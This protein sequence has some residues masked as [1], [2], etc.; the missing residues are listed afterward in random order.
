M[1]SDSMMPGATAFTRTPWVAHS[2]PRLIVRFS[3]PARAAPVCAMPGKPRDTFAVTFTM[4]PARCGISAR[5]A[6]SRVML[7]VPRRL[8]RTTASKPRLEIADA[9]AGN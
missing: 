7:N 9:G 5:T 8:L 3:T 6:T 2:T 4:E 1:P